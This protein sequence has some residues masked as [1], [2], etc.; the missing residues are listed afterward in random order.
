MRG[1]RYTFWMS[2]TLGALLW[3]Q[4]HKL[5]PLRGPQRG[6]PTMFALTGATLWLGPQRYLRDG[7]I[8]IKEGRIIQV[9]DRQ[10]IS[11]PAE[12]AI[13]SYP[14]NVWIYPAFIELWNHWGLRAAG[15]GGGS[16][17]QYDPTRHPA[18]YPADAV[19]I[20]YAADTAFTYDPEAAKKL[21][22]M[23]FAI[24]HIVPKEGVLRG[25]GT[26]VLLAD[27]RRGEERFLNSAL[28]FH[29]G[30][31]KGSVA[32]MYPTSKMGSI[33]LVRQVLYDWLWYRQFGRPPVQ[34]AS[35]ERL[36][37]LWRD[38]LRWVWVAQTPEDAFRVAKLSTEWRTAGPLRWALL[39]TGHEYEWL[40]YLPKDGLYIL[41]VGLPVLPPLHTADA[42]MNVP[43]SAL[44]RWETAPFRVKWLLRQGYSVALT[45]Q[46]MS[47]AASFWADL[48]TLART[49]ITADSVLLCLTE[50]PAQWL[51][52]P[53]AGRI[54]AGAWANLLLFSD[55]LWK[56]TAKL[57]EV[58][59]AGEREILEPLPALQPQGTY[60]LSVN[61]WVWEF[62]SKGLP[63]LST[64]LIV[65]EKDTQTVSV[66][67]D[68]LLQ[69]FSA[70]V[71]GKAAGEWSFEVK[72]ETLLLGKWLRPTGDISLWE[73]RRTS[74]PETMPTPSPKP[75]LS[76][77]SL[78]SRLTRPLGIYG[79][80]TLP[81]PRTVLIRGATVWTGDTILRDA[82]VLIA[83]G[84]IRRIGRNLSIPPHAEVI[85]AQGAALTAG[86]IDE[87]S[88]IAIEGGVN[89]YTDAVTAEV[90]IADVIDPTDVNIYRHL[91]S[92]VTTVQLLHGSA[93]P[94]G[95]QSACIKLR[96]GL[97]ADSLLFEGAPPFN[98]FALGENV[99][100]SNWGDAFTSRYPQTRMGVEQI[101]A[102]AFIAAQRYQAEWDAYEVAR[103]K[104]PRLPAPRRDLR[105][106]PLAEILKGKRF[107][108]CHSYVQSEIIMLMRLAERFGFR[109]RTFT[110]VL[111]GY[112]VAPELHK[113]GAYASTFSDWWAYKYEVID[114][115]PHNAAILLK[116]RVPTCINSDDAEMGRRL[117]QEA[118]KILRYGGAD[119]G[120]DSIEA[121]R[122]ITVYPA[123][124]LGISHR[125]GYVKEGY[126]ADVVLWDRPSPLSVYSKVRMTFV[127]GRRLYDRERDMA[128]YTDAL[129]EKRRLAE[130]A[131]EAAQTEK[132]GPP[133]LVRRAVLWHCESFHA[134][135]QP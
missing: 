95:G 77:D 38:T 133:L 63:P 104:N 78:I 65:G 79:R 29:A 30:F 26:T 131:W 31:D 101:I 52:I 16:S 73:A 110:H 112:K 12:A 132:K 108:T 28:I 58:W 122:T 24:A 39:G 81:A 118:A 53:D 56:E 5:M 87:H 105:L 23:G 121:W 126:D 125:V 115:I 130:K 2:A 90:R 46:G 128:A 15:G 64:R 88:H 107:I 116:Y 55:T 134:E 19:R 76:E 89:E 100:Q 117:N 135:E 94:I 3:A 51:G 97:P 45:S 1:G 49:G 124:A 74:L 92:G 44:R 72:A 91:A 10:R 70:R 27:R 83:E 84:K 43:L 60:A 21:R 48:R 69:R 36:R 7:V 40:P 61:S 80:D 98:K 119:L 13:I 93:N 57:L 25:T 37:V 14:S 62:P 6:A 41:P 8:L 123:Q 99:K 35:L 68:P 120:I 111:E 32:Q 18:Y 22:A 67:Y 34:N 59:T 102:D 96:W 20:D 4:P 114:A 42:Y 86:I 75:P 54:A 106:E 33:A 113:H 9:G 127:D 85:E 129:V 103:K 71:R 11:I 17:P 50:V 82:D 109:I 66:S 47:D